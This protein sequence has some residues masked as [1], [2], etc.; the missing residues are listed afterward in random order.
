MSFSYIVLTSFI[1]LTA[2][3][4]CSQKINF[5]T[6]PI[7]PA[8]RGT[9][10]VKKDNN[11]NYRIHISLSNLAEPDRLQPAKKTYVVWMET[12]ENMTK[13]I[14][15]INTSGSLLSSKLR[16]SFETVSTD[17]PNKIF[18]TAENDEMVQYPGNFV[19]MTTKSF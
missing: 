18:I 12:K 11:E 8:A 2:I 5:E 14:G 7:V 17:R 10:T 9:V 13:N 19:I 1:M 3:F 4:G 6:S 16:S 15:Q